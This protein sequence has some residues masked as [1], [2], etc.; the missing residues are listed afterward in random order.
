MERL[1]WIIWLGPKCN[2]KHP[3]KGVRGRFDTAGHVTIETR[4]YTAG[5]EA[6]ERGHKQRNLRSTALEAR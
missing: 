4:F 1:S 6:G 2:H 5:C 3:Y